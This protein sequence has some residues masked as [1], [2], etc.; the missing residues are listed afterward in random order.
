MR[1]EEMSN[2]ISQIGIWTVRVALIIGA[3]VLFACG[4]NSAG[5]SCAFLAILSFVLL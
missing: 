2:N 5:D 3:V 1:E 4:N